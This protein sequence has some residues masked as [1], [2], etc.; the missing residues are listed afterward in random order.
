MNQ[1]LS[2]SIQ[3]MDGTV[4]DDTSNKLKTDVDVCLDVI[5]GRE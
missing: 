3:Y 2:Y 4:F 5:G 1:K